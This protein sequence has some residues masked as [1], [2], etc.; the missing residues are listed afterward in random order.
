MVFRHVCHRQW[1]KI[2][3]NL[4]YLPH[5]FGLYK[6]SSNIYCSRALLPYT[7]NQNS[8][9]Y[10]LMVLLYNIDYEG[11]SQAIIIK[12]TKLSRLAWSTV[13]PSQ[14]VMNSSSVTRRWRLSSGLSAVTFWARVV[15]SR[16]MSIITCINCLCIKLI[17]P[18]ISVRNWFFKITHDTV[19]ADISFKQ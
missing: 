18:L 1:N 17:S 2:I 6:T 16:P 14:N 3:S 13:N 10:P 9:F 4:F 15:C 19:F 5:I 12:L 8:Y 7:L 11:H